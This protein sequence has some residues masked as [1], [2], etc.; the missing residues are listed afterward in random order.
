MTAQACAANASLA[1]IRSR[2]P[3]L[4]PAFF[5]AARDAGIGPVPMIFG[6]DA[7]L[8][9]RDDARRAA[10]C[11]A[12]AAS[13]AVISTTAA[14]PSLMPDALAGGDG[15]FLVEGGPQLGRSLR[16]WRRAA[17]IRRRR[18]RCRPCG[19][20]MVTGTI[21]S[22]NLPAFCA[23][24]ALFCEATANSSCCSRVICHWR[25]DVLGGVAHVVAVEGVPQAV[26]DH[27][28]DHVRGRPSSTPSRRYAQC[29]AMLMISWP[30]ATTISESPLSIA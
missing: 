4:Q 23:A 17:D 18:R 11:R 15:A 21:S 14:A 28:V 1:S 10:S 20:L 6:I 9:P 16:P 3:T 22:L 27:G 30:P 19:V 24:S 7:G 12:C 26:L 8:R 29:G 5:S 25:G 2:S 13:S